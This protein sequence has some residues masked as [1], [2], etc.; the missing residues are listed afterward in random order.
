M[1]LNRVLAPDY[2]LRQFVPGDGDGYS[3]FLK[4]VSWWHDFDA[5]HPEIAQKYF[6]SAER[7]AAFWKKSFFQRLLSKR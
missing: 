1:A 4:P 5:K 3:L 6:L 2:E 7:L